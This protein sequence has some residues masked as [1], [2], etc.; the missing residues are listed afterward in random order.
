MQ[1]IIPTAQRFFWPMVIVL[2]FV[3]LGLVFEA[4]RWSVYQAPS[5]LFQAGQ[6]NTILEKV[7]RL[8]Q[9]PTGET[10][11]IASIND[12][13]SAKKAQPFLSNAQNGDI[14]II[15]A[16]TSEA[17]LY[18]SSTDKLIA[19]GAVDDI[20]PPQAIPAVSVM[21]ASSSNVTTTS[22]VK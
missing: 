6:A 19:V 10:P 2:M 4:G 13:T 22:T 21:I 15:Y 11:T 18:R 14:L 12:A 20:A 8:I 5:E 9:L 1:R 17:I 16:R 3:V 7:G